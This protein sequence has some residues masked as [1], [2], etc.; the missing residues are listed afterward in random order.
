MMRALSGMPGIKT[1]AAA[2]AVFCVEN[3][4]SNQERLVAARSNTETLMVSVK[5]SL[6]RYL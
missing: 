5:G 6:Q 2:I 4:L 1:K 3:G